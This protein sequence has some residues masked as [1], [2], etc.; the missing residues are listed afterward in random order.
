MRGSP[1][2]DVPVDRLDWRA[3]VAPGG[4]RQL[5]VLAGAG[6]SL[7]APANLLDGGSFMR[8]VVRRAVPR[9]VDAEWALS[10][11]RLPDVPLRRPGE[12]LRFELLMHALVQHDLDPQLNVL[13]CFDACERPNGNHFALAELIHEGAIV[14]T[15]NFDRLIEIAWHRLYANEHLEIAVFNEDFPPSADDV[16]GPTLWKIHGSLSVDGRDTR[17]SVQATMAS[18]LS[19]SLSSR[20]AVFLAS[21]LRSRDVVVVGYSGWDDFDLVP[22][23]GD[24]M[25]T[26]RLTWIDHAPAYGG[27]SDA[28]QALAACTA[29]FECDA[30]GRD[31]V[32]FITGPRGEAIRDAEHTTC[33]SAD[34]ALV[35]GSLATG[36]PTGGAY[37]IDEHEFAFGRSHPHEVDRYFDTWERSME[38]DS[39]GRYELLAELHSLRR[40]RPE[41]KAI[42]DH[43]TTRARE[44]RRASHNPG[45]VLT[46]LIEDFNEGAPAGDVRKRLNA[47]MPALP[48]S[49]LG[50]AKRLDACIAWHTEG[51]NTGEARFRDAAATDR[52]IGNGA[53]EL[54]TLVTWRGFA[55]FSPWGDNIPEDASQR[56]DELANDL[57]YLP[58]IWQQELMRQE[59]LIDE[60]GD[61]VTVGRRLMRIRR[62]AIDVGD[63]LGEAMA[64][65]QLGRVYLLDQQPGLAMEE[66]LRVRELNR[67]LRSE[68]LGTHAAGFIEETEPYVDSGYVRRLLPAIRRSLWAGRDRE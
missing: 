3:L 45:E 51:A 36:F 42:I 13:N 14:V 4:P 6:V 53:N 9:G 64:G 34:T 27:I 46:T 47:L 17:R 35:L 49:L 48:A 67:I 23:I 61:F 60:D 54:N 41:S 19:T 55:G 44:L 59:D 57:G 25:S 33:V 30:V 18:A 68:R 22:I 37:S 24:T 2:A 31:R 16:A 66:F 26:R 11:L 39:P 28:T 5:A 40:F 12:M 20:K 21:V 58:V 15:T 50:S 65:L 38:P 62:H 56:I 10:A 8:Q 52:A 29:M 7:N 1:S 32:W 43:A 63:V